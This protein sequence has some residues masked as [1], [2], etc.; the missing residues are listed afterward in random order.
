VTEPIYATLPDYEALMM[1]LEQ[2][3][4]AFDVSFKTLAEAASL[5]PAFL[6]GAF[7][8]SRTRRLGWLSIFLLCP[9]LGLRVALIEA[10]ELAERYAQ[11]MEKRRANQARPGNYASRA[12][13]R[14]KIR[15]L[16]ELAKRGGERRVAKMTAQEH[17]EHGRLMAM[18]R[19]HPPRVVELHG[20]AAR[21]ARK[22]AVAAQ[23]DQAPARRRQSAGT[24]AP[25]GRA[26]SQS[27]LRPG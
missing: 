15:V 25:K 20:A 19:W 9:P 7:G 4:I 3:R 12:S 17:A 21:S 2:R 22:G 27:T 5:Q 1:A 16:R 24:G 11:G 23:R 10:P 8:P 13:K 6:S 26:R 14:V 18:A